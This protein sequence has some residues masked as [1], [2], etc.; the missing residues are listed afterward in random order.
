[1]IK[2]NRK[3]LFQLKQAF[4]VMYQEVQLICEIL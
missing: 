1:M 4:L 2:D 3:S